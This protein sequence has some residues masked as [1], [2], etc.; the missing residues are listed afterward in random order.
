MPRGACVA[1]ALVMTTTFSAN[2]SGAPA[3]SDTN[4]REELHIQKQD[5]LSLFD[6][7]RRH[8]PFSLDDIRWP[9]WPPAWLS[10]PAKVE[11]GG[12][13]ER[14]IEE[15]HFLYFTGSDV[16]PHWAFAHAGVLWSPSGLS[17]EGFTVK[18]LLNGGTYGYRAGALNDT[19]ILGRQSSIT[20]MPGWRFKRAGYE[21]AVFAG[22]DLQNYRLTPD[23][24]DNRLRGRRLGLR[25]GFELWHEPSTTTMLAAD[26][27]VSSIGAGNSARAAFG[28]R[29]FER[30]YLGPEAQ[31]YSTDSYIHKRVGVHITAFKI[32]ER[33][34]SGAIG[35]ASDNDNRSGIYV[36]I[37]VLT[38]H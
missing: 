32:D 22:F 5:S 9:R 37:G 15:L 10:K 21:V 1:V 30:F 34:W 14:H 31:I 20:A 2:V 23:D 35:L 3:K 12:R 18:L 8:L 17:N 38:R 25:A 11:T 16:W 4:G 24:P 36:R 33:E 7:L 27:S 19:N 26:A 29:L 6:D 28:W 13:E